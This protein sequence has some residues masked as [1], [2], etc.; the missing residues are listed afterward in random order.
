MT[1]REVLP[2]LVSQDEITLKEAAPLFANYIDPQGERWRNYEADA[3][4]LG[5]DPEL[6]MIYGKGEHGTDAKAFCRTCPVARICLA[7][8]YDPGVDRHAVRGNMTGGERKRLLQS[9]VMKHN[10]VVARRRQTEES[11]AA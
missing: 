6:F 2:E 1:Q 9:F 10:A 11:T 8:A 5:Q 4:C 3:A 7:A